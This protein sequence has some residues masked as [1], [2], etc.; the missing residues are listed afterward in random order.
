MKLEVVTRVT[1]DIVL[2]QVT[3]FY[4][5]VLGCLTNIYY[6]YWLMTYR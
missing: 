1:D 4:P 2:Y 3:N 5:T 6:T